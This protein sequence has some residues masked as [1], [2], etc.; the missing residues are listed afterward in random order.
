M[1]KKC[2]TLDGFISNMKNM[3]KQSKANAK[4]CPEPLQELCETGN[5]IIEDV[6]EYA[7][8]GANEVK[9]TGACF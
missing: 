3:I 1:A 2:K 7:I 9:E 6:M 5:D 8:D 4:K